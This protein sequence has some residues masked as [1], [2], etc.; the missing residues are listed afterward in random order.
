MTIE[1]QNSIRKLSFLCRLPDI[2]ITSINRCTLCLFYHQSSHPSEAL[3]PVMPSFF[4]KS[5]AFSLIMCPPTATFRSRTVINHLYIALSMES[6]FPTLSFCLFAL[7]SLDSYLL[8]ISFVL[9]PVI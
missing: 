8:N 7:I 6:C 2:K 4:T 3:K 1:F 5:K 9:N